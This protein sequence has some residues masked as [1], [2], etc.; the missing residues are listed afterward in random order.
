M[1]K[2]YQN[3]YAG[4]E[5]YFVPLFPVRARKRESPLIGGYAITNMNGEWEC[6]KTQ[7]Y[8]H[9]LHDEEHFPVVGEVKIDILDY[10]M[11]AML[12][13]LERRTDAAD[14]R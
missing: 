3:K 8:T 13:A 12:D 4:Y 2:I 14:K 10:V 7:Y 9:S 11:D 1:A 5:T 6:R